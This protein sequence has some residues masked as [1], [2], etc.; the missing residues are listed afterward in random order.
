MSLGNGAGL[1]SAVTETEARSSGTGQ[2]R[3]PSSRHCS[4]RKIIRAELIGS[5]SCTALGITVEV[6]SPVLAMCRALIAAGHDPAA[7]LDAFRG[8]LL[9]LRVRSIGEGA[10]LRVAT[11]GRGFERLLECTAASPMRQ[12]DGGGHG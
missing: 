9:C 10:G 12:N 6:N 5:E 3:E 7:R 11:H 4:I 8:N 2:R 1:I